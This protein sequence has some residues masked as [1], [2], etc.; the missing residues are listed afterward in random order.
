MTAAVY[1]RLRVADPGRWRAVARAWRRWAALAG[2]LADQLTTDLR[3]LGAA[4]SGAA[5]TAALSRVT[6]LRRVL[7]LFRVLCWQAD[8]AASEFAAALDRAKQL[9]ARALSA[10]HRHGLTIDDEGNVR[11]SAVPGAGADHHRAAAGTTPG[12]I[13]EVARDLH[14]AV[15]IAARADDTAADRLERIGVAALARAAPPGPER[16]GCTASPAAVRR[17]WDALA[18]GERQWLLATEPAWLA[19]LDGIPAADRDAANRLLLDDRRAEIDRALATA[20]SDERRRLLGL[21][22][23]LDRLTDRLDDDAGSR[24]YLLRLDLREEGRVVMALGDPDRADNVVTHVPGM[25]AELASFGG[26]LGRAERVAVRATELSPAADTSAVLWLDYDAPDF[27]DEA[28]GSRRAEAGAPGLRRFQD[29]LR[30][31]AE[32]TPARQT[33]IGH[34]YGSLVVGKAAAGS[35]LTADSVVFVGSP[36]V[37]VDSARDLAVPPDRVWS[38]TSRNDIIQYAT[39]APGAF[40]R[41]LVVA[42]VVPGAG[43]LIAFGTPEN[44][45]WFGHNPSDPAFGAHTFPSSPDAGHLGY[46]D[47]GSPSLDT[48]AAITLGTAR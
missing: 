35:G 24:A 13:A 46:W 37:G 34:S 47:R 20:T 9:L 5:A 44:D 12:G 3:R 18:P 43:P 15:A 10:A 41:D 8:Q 42:G 39:P 45:L 14:A 33:V 17:W 19:P 21:R 32:G 7:V 23:G 2:R 6:A 30:A 26:E 11:V 48:L 40:A 27:V 25:T 4:W 16:P 1:A 31:T 36:G 29:G 22:D 28:A 38:T